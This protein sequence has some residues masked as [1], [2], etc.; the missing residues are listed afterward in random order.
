MDEFL[1]NIVTAVCGADP[2]LGSEWYELL[3]RSAPSQDDHEWAALVERISEVAANAGAHTEGLIDA[4]AALPDPAELQGLIAAMVWPETSAE[5]G[6]APAD[7]AQEDEGAWNKYLLTNG[8]QWDGT[9]ASWDAFVE[10]FLY[11]AAEQGVGGFARAFCTYA[12]EVGPGEVFDQYG[13]TLHAAAAPASDE[14]A[15]AEH[16]EGTAE[17]EPAKA[18]EAGM[19]VEAAVAEYGPALYAE[20]REANPEFAD[21]TDDDLAILLAEA[22]TGQAELAALSNE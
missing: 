11:H 16:G 9:M 8:P 19:S 1:H 18:Q 4:L 7:G 13:V 5:S 10:W 6:Q 12:A 14:P 2:Q 17:P 15:V 22:L 3:G 20:F 21:L